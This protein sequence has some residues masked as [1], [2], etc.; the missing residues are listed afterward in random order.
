M[1]SS[2]REFL[3]K[4]C[5][6]C[7]SLAGSAVLLS[8]LQSCAPLLSLEL[9]PQNNRIQ[10]PLDSF[11]EGNKVVL[12]TNK[13]QEFDIAVVQLEDQKYKALILECTHFSNQLVATKT[14]F[15]CNAHGSSFHLDGSVNNAPAQ[16]NLKEYKLIQEEN[17]LIIYL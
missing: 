3:R 17:Q 16:N 11:K 10:V 7:A 4:S 6:L 12:V 1:N 14:G 2:R 13:N 15:F 9:E 8:Y 5:G